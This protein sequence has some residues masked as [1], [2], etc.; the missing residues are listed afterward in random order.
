MGDKNPK[1]VPKK[2]GNEKPSAASN[3][4]KKQK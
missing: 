1:K 3:S 2:K 4:V